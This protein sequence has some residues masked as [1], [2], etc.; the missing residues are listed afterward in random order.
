MRRGPRPAPVTLTDD[1]RQALTS[2]AHRSRTAPQLARRARIILACADGQPTRGIAKRLRLSPTTV[3]KWRTRFLAD[4]LDGLTDEPRPGAPR[5]ITDA[6]VEDVVVRTLESTPRGATHWST[7]TLARTTGLSHATIGRIWRA[8]GLQPHRTE[9]FKLSPDPWLIDKVR[10]VVGLYVAPPEHAVVF[11][12]DEKPQI[13]A[14]ERTAPLLPMLPGQAERR[15]FDY[16]R[17]GTTRLFAALD[18]KT[19]TVIGQL[20]RRHRSVEFE[21]FLKRIDDETPAE[22][23]VHLILDNYSTHRS[24]RIRRWLARHPRFH[25]HFTP[26]YSSWLNLVERWFAELTTKQLRRAVH[27][28][29][30]AGDSRVPRPVQRPRSPVR[31]DEDGRRD[32]R[33]HRPVRAADAHSARRI[34]FHEPLIQD[35]STRRCIA[36][37]DRQHRR[38]RRADRPGAM[39]FRGTRE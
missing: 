14:L 29:P 33:E 2:L 16:R 28:G 31:M 6:Q 20:H 9:A 4:R 36:S 3:C 17:H 37:G 32:P 38:V 19:G 39:A 15:S 5:R 26:T 21:K 27:R 35:T 24:P 1:E 34:M 22:L 23:D 7:R 18:V 8:F 12:V 25:L 13:Q 10:D 30:R 11:C